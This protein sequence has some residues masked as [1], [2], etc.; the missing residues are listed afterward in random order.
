VT[1]AK[2]LL[3]ALVLVT[4]LALQ[5]CVLNRLP[6]PGGH[7]DLLLVAVVACA[8]TAGPTAGAIT[9][10]AA[11][12]AADVVPPADHPLG[13]LA[14]LLAIA[15]YATGLLDELEEHSVLAS[16]ALVAAASAGLTVGDALVAG[17]A[18]TGRVS[19]EAFVRSLVAAV[20]YDVV[21]TPFVVPLVAA[22]ARRLGS[23]PAVGRPR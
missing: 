14:L 11:G 3:F 13:M 12:L 5:I 4:A 18:G 15:G 23:W 20:V 17:L 9:G 1:V 21:L 19:G 6:L 22:L 7:A 8:L 2:T 10:F 16:M